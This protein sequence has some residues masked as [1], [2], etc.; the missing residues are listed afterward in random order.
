MLCVMGLKGYQARDIS[1]KAFRSFSHIH[2]H[3]EKTRWRAVDCRNKIRMNE[4]VVVAVHEISRL[5]LMYQHDGSYIAGQRR[6]FT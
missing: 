4:G 1:P 5:A 6:R 3:H 2:P